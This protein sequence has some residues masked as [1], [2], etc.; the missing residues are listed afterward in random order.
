MGSS[1]SAAEWDTIE[2]ELD[3]DESR[4][5]LPEGG[6]E[7]SLVLSSFNIRK[8]GKIEGRT[9]ELRFLA[10]FCAR[11]DLVAIQEVQ[12][13]LAGLLRLKEEMEKQVAGGDEFAVVVS[14]ITGQVP[15]DSGMSERL[16][17]I[18]RRRRIRRAEMASDISIDATGV[19][20]NMARH[21][22]PINA[23]LASERVVAYER[24]YRQYREE[25][26]KYVAG[27]ADRIPDLPKKPD[28]DFKTFL[29]FTRT[30]HV[31]A[32]DAPAAHDK[33]PLRFIAV[34]THLVYG[35]MAE[36][37]REFEALLEWI[38]YR[39][40][41][42]DRLVAPNFILLGDL[43]LDFDRPQKDRAVIEDRLKTLNA[44]AFGRTSNR[45]AYFPFI[46]PHPATGKVFRTNARH[47]Q[48]FDQIGFF[49]GKDERRLPNDLWRGQMATR[50]PDDSDGF[51]YGVFNFADLFAR[52]LTGKA[53]LR[54]SKS[55]KTE[56][57][58]KFEHRVSDHMPIWVRLPRPGMKEPPDLG[59]R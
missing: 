23:E 33:P 11:C 5:G 51:D 55:E 47:N 48:T 45:R 52:A 31:A 1:F 32:F 13:K 10:K 54:L 56:L 39:L 43:N 46:D 34:N 53:Y 42:D 27:T 9:R 7:G 50:S 21:R 6:R 8:L 26:D 2:A 28:V 15:G 14:D 25:L 44:I 41:D 20:L 59:N 19:L 16:A 40:R 24:A 35:K 29:T 4:Y 17:F 38:I 57:G 58:K 36:R 22:G 49:L 18:F 12:D 3:G 37:R 30:P